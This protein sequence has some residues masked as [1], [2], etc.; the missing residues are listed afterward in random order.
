MDSSLLGESRVLSGHAIGGH[1]W[2]QCRGGTHHPLS[3][4]VRYIEDAKRDIR[5]FSN[6]IQYYEAEKSDQA[7]HADINARHK[8]LQ[9]N[10]TTVS[11]DMP[12]LRNFARLR[13]TNLTDD[14]LYVWQMP[15][16]RC[17]NARV[18]S[19]IRSKH[20]PTRL[21][22]AGAFSQTQSRRRHL[23]SKFSQFSWC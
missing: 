23:T 8:N 9:A 6:G 10:V 2:V 17:S 22:M 11:T 21:A 19:C 20:A 13:A 1:F 4:F 14:S 3:E 5:A 12:R 15:C 18:R 16:L 7:K